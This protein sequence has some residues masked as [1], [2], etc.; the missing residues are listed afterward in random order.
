VIVQPNLAAAYI[1]NCHRIRCSNAAHARQVEQWLQWR[2]PNVEI[3]VE[4]E[5]RA[6]A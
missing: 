3:L 4:I 5:E 6:V 2:K 1:G